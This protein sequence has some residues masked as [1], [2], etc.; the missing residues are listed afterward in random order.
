MVKKQAKDKCAASIS[1]VKFMKPPLKQ[2]K[3]GITRW[4]YLN[5]IPFNVST[6]SEFRSI[7]KNHH[8]NYTVLS[9]ITF[10][11]NVTHDYLCF[12]IACAEKLK[13]RIQ[14][15]HGEP[16]LHVMHAMVTLND[17][18]NYLGASV[19]FMVDF[20]LYILAVAFIPNNVSHSSNY[21]ADLLQKILKETFELDIS[22][23]TMSVASDTTNS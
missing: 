7:N 14:Q 5:R 6:S 10:I 4:L 1:M 21:N 3:V 2:H 20:D 17:R 22:L 15:H 9:R 19:S 12:F 18:N 13:R 8:D 16:F 23:F 11:D